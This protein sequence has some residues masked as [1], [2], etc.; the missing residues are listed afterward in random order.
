MQKVNERATFWIGVLIGV[1]VLTYGVCRA[2]DLRWVSDDAFITFRYVQNLLAG[3]GPVYNAGEHVEG[4]THFL[5]FIL[6]SVAGWFGAD[7]VGTSEW[8]GIASFA[9]TLL[10]FLRIAKLENNRSENPKRIFLPLAAV[11]LALNLD[12]TEWASGGLETSF[13]TF[14]ISLA[15]YLW[16]YAEL[17][18]NRRLLSVGL[19]LIL[20]TLTRPDG[21]LFT[22]TALVLLFFKLRKD[23]ATTKFLSRSLFLLIAPSLIIGIPYLIWK[24]SYYGDI[25]PNTYYQKSGGLSYFGQGFE[26]VYLFASVYWSAAIGV[27]ILPV[28]PYLRD[29]ESNDQLVSNYR[30]P[31]KTHGFPRSRE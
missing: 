7:I 14:L 25:F 10:I 23:K 30:A 19:V 5:W 6:L 27:I 17:T 26:Y 16:F 31:L 29:A 4:Y 12:M 13:Y 22:L 8:L 20:T 1:A 21:A 18:Y 2:I 15:F 9:G 28:I 3:L 11:L 24:L